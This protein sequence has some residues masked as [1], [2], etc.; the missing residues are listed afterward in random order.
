MFYVANLLP[1]LVYIGS[2]VSFMI[3][4]NTDNNLKR[5][6]EKNQMLIIYAS[7]Y[8]YTLIC[9]DGGMPPL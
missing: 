9:W 7:T 1:V 3:N 8:S 4:P 6:K 2:N 5:R